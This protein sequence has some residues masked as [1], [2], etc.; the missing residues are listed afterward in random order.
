MS[1]D[2]QP[3]DQTRPPA[4]FYPDPSGGPARRWWDGTGWTEKLEGSDWSVPVGPDGRPIQPELAAGTKVDT[5]FIWIFALLPLVSLLS[6]AFYDVEEAMR[7][8]LENP[9]DP[10]A[11]YTPGYFAASA[12]SWVIYGASVV[13]AFFDHRA[14]TRMGVVR[15]FHWAWAFLFTIPY[16]IGRAVVLRRR[17]RRGLA[18]MWVYLAT[19]VLGLVVSF[20]VVI[21]ATIT[22]FQET[23]FPT[24]P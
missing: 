21:G 18:P 3:G 4:G 12:I 10:T 9:S 1:D 16:P 11:T 8:A 14:L 17:V 2:Q 19:T 7:L 22:A 15:P 23:G 13:L 20:A 5:P 24:A 6:F